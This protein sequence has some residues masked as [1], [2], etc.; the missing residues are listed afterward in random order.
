MHTS[1]LEGTPE[2]PVQATS[3]SEESFQIPIAQLRCPVIIEVFC[4]SARVTASLKALGLSSSCGADHDTSKAVSTAKKLD[5]T[6]SGDQR[7]FLQWLQSPLVVG[8][9]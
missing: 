8:V 2:V 7:I 1:D 3:G 4:G 9:L 6:D 5:L